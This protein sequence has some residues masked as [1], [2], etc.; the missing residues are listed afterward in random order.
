[1]VHGW[2]SLRVHRIEVAS[3]NETFACER[4]KGLKGTFD[5]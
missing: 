2:L 4:C 3:G 5:R 1:M